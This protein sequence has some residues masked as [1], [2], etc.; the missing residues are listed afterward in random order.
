MI[1][2][3]TGHTKDV[4]MTCPSRLCTLLCTQETAGGMRSSRGGSGKRV[5]PLGPRRRPRESPARP[6]QPNG[7][8]CGA[9]TSAETTGTAAAGGAAGG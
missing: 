7:S 9:P 4:G 1:S 5:A 6:S 8:E 2:I 3:D